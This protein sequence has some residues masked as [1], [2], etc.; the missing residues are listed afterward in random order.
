MNGKTF[1]LAGILCLTS[2]GRTDGIFWTPDE[3]Q[4]RISAMQQIH[5]QQQQQERTQENRQKKLRQTQ[6][7][8]RQTY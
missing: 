2:C 4:N 8:T 6:A 5:T 3:T 7:E 1:I